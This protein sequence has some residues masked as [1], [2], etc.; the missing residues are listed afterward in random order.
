MSVR[1]LPPGYA[2][3]DGIAVRLDTLPDNT[4]EEALLGKI[5]SVATSHGFLV[6]HTYRSTKSEPGFPDLILCNGVSLLMYELKTNTGQLTK[7]QALWLSLLAHTEK[8]ESGIW[9]PRD[10]PAIYER[11]TRRTR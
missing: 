1:G 4:P 2:I 7:E 11:L 9:R 3:K 8:V 10:W 6:Y 5:R